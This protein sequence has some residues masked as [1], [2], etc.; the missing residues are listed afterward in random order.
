MK[1]INEEIISQAQNALHYNQEQMAEYLDVDRTYLYKIRKGKRPLNEFQVARIADAIK[2][3]SDQLTAEIQAATEPDQ[4]K[5]DYWKHR[6]RHKTAAWL[7]PAMTVALL[8]ILPNDGHAAI[9]TSNVSAGWQTRINTGLDR[10]YTTA[11]AHYAT[12]RKMLR[13]LIKEIAGLVRSRTL[14]GLGMF[15]VPGP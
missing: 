2:K 8:G 12:W 6:A 10:P 3:R 5:R 4:Q 11:N 7:L 9:N 15:A 14:N 13:A 1:H